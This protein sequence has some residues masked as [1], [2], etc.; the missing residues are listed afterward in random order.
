MTI[1]VSILVTLFIF[2]S[3]AN[4]SPA[5][6]GK[7]FAKLPLKAQIQRSSVI[8]VAT[9]KKE[10][11]HLKCVV[12]EILKHDP[13][14]PFHYGIGDIYARGDLTDRPNTDF[15]DGQVMFF[16]GSAPILIYAASYSNDR[17]TVLG[18]MT[19]SSFREAVRA[20]T[21]GPR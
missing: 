18:D 8:L 1:A 21:E 12:S 2:S 9:W 7:E 11:G 6:S 17:I 15:G 14:V 3:R 10:N 13:D 20:G 4:F 19:L 16:T 5:G